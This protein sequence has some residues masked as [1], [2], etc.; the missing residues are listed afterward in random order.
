MLDSQPRC[1]DFDA[2]DRAHPQ[3]YRVV[4]HIDD[5]FQQGEFATLGRC[6]RSVLA[7]MTA[8]GDH[9]MGIVRTAGGAEFHFRFSRREDAERLAS[10]LAQRG[11]TFS[12]ERHFVV[13][14]ALF[15]SLIKRRRPRPVFG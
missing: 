3:A 11:A 13:D 1:L 8:A 14:E 9:A 10:C 4:G 5:T 12:A 2:F 6:L 7:G 15:N